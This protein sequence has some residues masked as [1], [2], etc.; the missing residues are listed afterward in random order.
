MTS[1]IPGASE[2]ISAMRTR[3]SQLQSS[4]EYYES[5]IADQTTQ[6][7]RLNQAR[8]FIDEGPE[9]TEAESDTIFYQP[10]TEED[11]KQEEEEVRRLEQKKKGL[12]ER[13]NSMGRDI[14]GVLR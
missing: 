6:L 9:E 2:R 14:S 4:I 11:L 3:Y 10:M 5:R 13:V 1:P 7:N 12:E 8:E